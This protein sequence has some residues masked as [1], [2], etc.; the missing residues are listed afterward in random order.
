M[1]FLSP[2]EPRALLLAAIFAKSLQYTQFQLVFFISKM[3][4]FDLKIPSLKL[5]NK[6]CFVFIPTGQIEKTAQD[7]EKRLVTCL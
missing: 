3:I 7:G 2:C 4:Y 1:S 5:A 6:S